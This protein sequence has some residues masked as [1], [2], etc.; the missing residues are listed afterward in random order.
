MAIAALFGLAAGALAHGPAMADGPTSAALEGKTIGE[1]ASY[2]R[3]YLRDIEAMEQLS[4]ETKEEIAKVANLVNQYDPELLSAGFLA[5]HGLLAAEAEDYVRDVR[6]EAE[7]DPRRLFEQAALNELYLSS[8]PHSNAALA[9]VV[10]NASQ[11]VARIAAVGERLEATGYAMLNPHL[12]MPAAPHAS[13]RSVAAL[14]AARY[15]AK[16]ADLL[17]VRYGARGAVNRVLT[18]AAHVAVPGGAEADTASLLA[19][20]EA[21]Q[22]LRWASLN[23][24]QCLAAAANPP[25][26]AYCA[27]KHGLKEVSA[28]WRNIARIQPSETRTADAG[29]P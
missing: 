29:A 19:D 17:A 24:A 9:I 28:C 8:R 5:H 3:A 26:E 10:A 20:K 18:T 14:D 25:E 4:F 22:C 15:V 6:S 27:G 7:D 12:P 21:G 16:E 1:V 11:E 13:A 2:Y 23:L